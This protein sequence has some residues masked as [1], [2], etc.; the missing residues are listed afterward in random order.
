M[1][2]APSNVVSF[3][4]RRKGRKQ[5][6]AYSELADIDEMIAHAEQRM[7]AWV[8]EIVRLARERKEIAARLPPP[9]K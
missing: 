8:A 2:D 1:A 4:T 5:R 9:V 3:P 6:S 7:H